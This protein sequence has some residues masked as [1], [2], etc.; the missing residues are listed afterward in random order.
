MNITS[1]RGPFN[2]KDK[3]TGDTLTTT[4][5]NWLNIKELKNIKIESPTF[6]ESPAKVQSDG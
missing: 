5:P 6:T 4:D 1:W 2:F 3:I